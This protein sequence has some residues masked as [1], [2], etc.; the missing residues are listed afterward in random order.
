LPV[1]REH[2]ELGLVGGDAVR[3]RGE[4][5]ALPLG[6]HDQEAGLGLLRDEAD[7]ALPVD[8]QDRVLDRAETGE[9]PDE[10]E[11][12]DPRRQLPRHWRALADPEG[13][14]PGGGPFRG[15]PVL[16]ERERPL[17]LVDR[18]LGVGRQRGAPLDQLPDVAGVLDHHCS[19]PKIAVPLDRS[20]VARLKQ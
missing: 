20:T 10:D 18:E 15:V 17:V 6:R 8:R 2:L 9:R 4:V 14:E 19:A 7:L 3:H 12:L 1:G 5:G 11:R 13:G 16:A